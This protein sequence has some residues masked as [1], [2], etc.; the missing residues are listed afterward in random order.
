MTIFK[1]LRDKK[2][3]QSGILFLVKISFKNEGEVKIFSDKNWDL[4]V[5]DLPYNKY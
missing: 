1:V 5:V 4:S 3:C 2:I